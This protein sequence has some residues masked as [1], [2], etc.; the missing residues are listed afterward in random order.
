MLRRPFLQLGGLA[1]LA[2]WLPVARAHHGWSSF[3]QGR[4]LYLEG[5]AVEVKWRNPHVELVLEARQPLVLPADLAQRTLPA[6]S[7]AVDGQGL[8]AK[9]QLPTRSDRRWE[10]E[11][12][13]LSRVQQWQVPEITVGTELALLGFTF[14]GEKG[15]AVFRAEY[16]FLGGK[17]YGMRSSPT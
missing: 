9:A 8:L 1:A 6:Q 16:L 3:D 13:P 5:R 10:I 12:A 7:A 17:V 2:A 4:P 14:S 15:A 11:L